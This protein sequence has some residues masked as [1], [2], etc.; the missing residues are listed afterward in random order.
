[1]RV[2]RGLLFWC[3][4]FITAGAVALAVQQGYL[5]R[6]AVADACRLWPLILIAIGLS[7]IARRTQWA[8]AGTVLSA[9]VIGAI[10][11][12]FTAGSEGLGYLILASTASFDTVEGFSSLFIITILG[13]A[14]FEAVHVGGRYLLPPPERG[15]R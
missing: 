4:G 11:G 2:S 10:V 12:E 9:V 1:M 7:L 14:L 13:I 3:L 15:R 8:I 5:D 6:N